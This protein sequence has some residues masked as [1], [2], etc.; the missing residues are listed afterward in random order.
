MR[1]EALRFGDYLGVTVLG[2][3]GC[4]DVGGF[5]DAVDGEAYALGCFGEG[6]GRCGDG[7]ALAVADIDAGF[8]AA[9]P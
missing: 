6:F 9:P 3:W 4:C 8:E 1:R 7:D 2:G 5:E